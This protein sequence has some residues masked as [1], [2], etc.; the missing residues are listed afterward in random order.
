MK[1]L[2]ELTDAAQQNWLASWT[3]GPVE[4]EGP[5]LAKGTLA[6]DLVLL[7]DTGVERRLSEF[8]GAQPALLMFWRHFGCGCGAARARRLVAEYP[9]YVEAGLAPVI[10]AQGEPA[11]AAA[12]RER[13]GLPCPILSDPDHQAY[14][15]YGLGQWSVERILYD[16]SPEYLNHE[17]ELGRRFQADRAATGTPLVDD[18]WRAVGEFVIG[19]DGRV[20]LPYLYQYCEDFPEPRVLTTAA[21]LSR[22]TASPIP[23]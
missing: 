23:A 4:A 13:H 18:P 6:R 2:E 19:T 7:D 17:H 8:W 11:R 10:I 1:T 5:G 9:S 22:A 3:S 20:R 12:Y 14:R 21:R 16:A 15:A